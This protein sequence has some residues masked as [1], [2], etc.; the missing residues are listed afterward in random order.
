MAALPVSVLMLFLI[1]WLLPNGRVPWRSVLPQALLV[2]VALEILKYINLASWPLLN[3]KLKAEY[4]PFVYSV[5]I[6]L[7][8]FLGAMV[9]LAG[10]EWAARR[11][12]RRAEAAPSIASPETPPST[13]I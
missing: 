10:A 9:I 2:G 3:R 12:R 8:S 13:I 4:G 7:W 1:Y 11:A 6:I 5:A